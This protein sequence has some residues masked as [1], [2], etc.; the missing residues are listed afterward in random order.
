MIYCLFFLIFLKKILM[1]FEIV[2][3][4]AFFQIY[5]VIK[6]HSGGFLVVN[7]NVLNLLI[8]MKNLFF[9]PT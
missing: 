8:V 4:N 7:T 9:L 6:L 2:Q 1:C 5:K 3:K